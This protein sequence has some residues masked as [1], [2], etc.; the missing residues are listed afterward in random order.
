MFE[1]NIKDMERKL[2]YYMI[3]ENTGSKRNNVCGIK[4][5]E[6]C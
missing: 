3:E 4:I 1:G 6:S 2:Y 5:K